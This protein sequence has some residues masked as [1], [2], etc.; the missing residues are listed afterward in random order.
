MWQCSFDPKD[1]PTLKLLLAKRDYR[2]LLQKFAKTILAEEN[3][4][5]WEHVQRFKVEKK[6]KRRE[7]L[8]MFV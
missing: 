7:R 2:Q 8:K 3:V 1:P 6:S 4:M 5:F